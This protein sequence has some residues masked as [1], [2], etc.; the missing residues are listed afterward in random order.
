MQSI[1]IL[2]YKRDDLS[3]CFKLHFVKCDV[4]LNFIN[5]SYK[6]LLSLWNSYFANHIKRCILSEKNTPLTTQTKRK[7]KTFPSFLLILFLEYFL[8][9][10]VLGNLRTSSHECTCLRVTVQ[11]WEQPAT[12]ICT[13]VEPKLLS[14]QRY[15]TT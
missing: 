5:I 12:T 11:P 10:L 3:I 13:G 8:G 6:L 2:H 14:R 7:R 4:D 15:A 9:Q 1:T